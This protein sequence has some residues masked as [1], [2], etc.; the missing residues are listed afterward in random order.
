MLNLMI[1]EIL[2]K[3][4]AE[5]KKADKIA[6]LR[7]HN[8]LAL[9]DVLRAAYDDT[10]QF[11][12]PADAPPYESKL[13]SDGNSSATLHHLTTRFTYFVKGGKGD[14]LPAIKR[15]R[16][17]LEILEGVH[18]KEAELVIAMKDKKMAGRY[19]GITKELVKEVWPKLIAQ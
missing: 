3:A 12:L 6:V 14:K 4:G 1:H 19:R 2:E 15:E 10:I 5:S 17:F 16:L 8:C 18:P 7:K 13:S 11:I 9:R